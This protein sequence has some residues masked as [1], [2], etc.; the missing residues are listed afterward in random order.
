MKTVKSI[1]KDSKLYVI[2][3][4]TIMFRDKIFGGQPKSREI[5]EKWIE[6]K[7]EMPR[8]P[9]EEKEKVLDLEEE[10]E[11]VWCGFRRNGEGIYIRDFQV[12]ALLSQCGTTLGITVKTRGSKGI[13]QHGL[14]VGP[15]EIH[16]LDKHEAD[17][18]DDIAG[19]VMTPQGKRSILKRCDYV[20]HAE[21][22]FELK[23]LEGQKKLTEKDLLKML[24]LG[25]ENGLGSCRSMGGGK[26]DVIEFD[27]L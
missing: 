2:Y 22:S 24:H 20:R 15:R 12:E 13:I 18:Y 8:E 26:F 17:G 21:L 1:F 11:Q 4:V 27:K 6:S 7:G 16:F 19:H 25:Q 3:R 23:L 10:T 14:H 9:M 5:L